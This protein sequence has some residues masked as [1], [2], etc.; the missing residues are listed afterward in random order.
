MWQNFLPFLK[1]LF[2]LI[3]NLKKFI[4]FLRLNNTPFYGWATFCLFIHPSVD[5]G[6]L[7]CLAV[8][9]DTQSTVSSP[10]PS[11][12]LGLGF[13]AALG[14]WQRVAALQRVS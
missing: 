11:L 4:S 10:L 12:H 6:G 2:F 9:N 14:A 5:I 1:N 13:S 8:E 7:S 3:K